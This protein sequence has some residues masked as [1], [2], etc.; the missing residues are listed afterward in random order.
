MTASRAP[1]EP[2]V[3]EFAATVERVDG[4]EIAL[5]QTF[6]YPESG[7]QPADRGT[8]GGIL[9]EDVVER[10]G[11]V[12]HVL[13]EEPGDSLASGETVSAVIDDRF[14]T[15]CTRAHTAS[16][17]LY[18]AARR[19]CNDLGYAGF[20]ISPEKV[21]VDLTTAEPLDD[22]DLVELERLATRTVWES[23]PV[24]W[25]TLSEHDA[26][27][28][29]GIAF[30][31]K[32]E[33]GAMSGTDA[34]RVVT[35]GGDSPAD[36]NT[37]TDRTDSATQLDVEPWDVAA[38][39]GTH[40]HDTAEIGPISVLD[41]S[42]PGE[43]VTR[44][45]FAVGPTAIDH[46]AAIHAAALETATSL[47]TR[48]GELPDEVRRLR[49]KA[50]DLE[51]ELRTAKTELLRGR[52]REFP[53]TEVDG[54]TWA[55]GT[56]ENA[57]PNALRDP[58]EAVLSGGETEDTPPD[59]LAAVGAEDAP[60]LVVAV[61]DQSVDIDAGDVV[62]AATDEFGGGG[63]GGPTFAQGGG[64]DADSDTIVSWLRDR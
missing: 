34:V 21:R 44:V 62:A 6:F 49:T 63:G 39:G 25:E 28:R 61:G 35:V 47:D 27:E 60:F 40:V 18:G 37:G 1:A 19:I 20:D 45:E 46:D 3:R 16:H 9:V 13:G 42:N 24:S 33:E 5:E 31:T 54:A 14:R 52:L 23:L 32:T 38:C 41:R 11:Q 7:G 50:D 2:D 59:V 26:R 43:G 10:N 56:V 55:I 48:I 22:S 29:E 51:D 64:I 12:V 36:K 53:T 15:Y 57:D 17:V 8:I 30:N 4:R 58:A